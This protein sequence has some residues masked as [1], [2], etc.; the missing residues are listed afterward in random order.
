MFLLVVVVFL[1]LQLQASSEGNA[2]P[3]QEG[4]KGCWR[5]W[6]SGC[7]APCD[8]S[9]PEQS[10]ARGTKGQESRCCRDSLQQHLH[11]ALSQAF[12]LRTGAGVPGSGVCLVNMQL[13]LVPRRTLRSCQPQDKDAPVS[14]PPLEENTICVIATQTL[15]CPPPR[16][17]LNIPR[18]AA[19]QQEQDSSHQTDSSVCKCLHVNW[20]SQTLLK[21]AEINS[22][23]CI[24]ENISVQGR[25]P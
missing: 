24:L 15:P 9:C 22:F 18:T 6:H 14:S 21:S 12:Q 13:I 20:F 25:D 3:E 4:A 5:R 23:F 1:A 11:P 17:V 19:G 8:A 10:P 7:S 2:K 16:G